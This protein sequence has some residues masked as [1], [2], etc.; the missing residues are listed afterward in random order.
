MTL[1]VDT[2]RYK[3]KMQNSSSNSKSIWNQQTS[4]NEDW[5]KY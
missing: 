3:V 4:R 2:D 1:I 5:I